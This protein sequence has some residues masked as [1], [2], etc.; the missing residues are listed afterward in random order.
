MDGWM[1][2]ASRYGSL[3]VN[4]NHK[5]C[6]SS[7]IQTT[8][9]QGLWTL[10]KWE[11]ER[12]IRSPNKKLIFDFWLNIF[13]A[14]LYKICQWRCKKNP[15]RTPQTSLWPGCKSQVVEQGFKLSKLQPS[16]I[17][18]GWFS[19]LNKNTKQTHFHLQTK[20]CVTVGRSI[21]LGLE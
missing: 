20:Q 14:A 16:V 1:D 4:L 21:R 13:G 9:R 5:L 6:K 10:F 7:R 17:S 3:S 2:G 12:P 18:N 15:L 11:N 8:I 19:S